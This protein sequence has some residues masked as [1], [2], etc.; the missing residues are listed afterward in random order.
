MDTLRPYLEAD[1]RSIVDYIESN[2]RPVPFLDSAYA[3]LLNK[4]GNWLR[5]S[6]DGR[7]PALDKIHVELG[8]AIIESMWCGWLSQ[9]KANDGRYPADAPEELKRA[10]LDA[11]EVGQEYSRSRK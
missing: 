6:K 5:I 3:N 7:P 9:A 8:I 2:Q 11:F 4:L 10:I 1:K